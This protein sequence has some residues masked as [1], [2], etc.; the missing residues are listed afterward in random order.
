MLRTSLTAKIL[1]ENFM[2]T[3][4]IPDYFERKASLLLRNNKTIAIG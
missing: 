2:I 1:S 3:Q 4:V